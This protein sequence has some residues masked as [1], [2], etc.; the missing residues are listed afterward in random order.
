MPGFLREAVFLKENAG[1][2][3]V[4][5]DLTADKRKSESQTVHEQLTAFEKMIIL[6][7]E[8]YGVSRSEN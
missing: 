8:E 5:L 2:L 3:F 6:Y 1:C 4:N 7:A